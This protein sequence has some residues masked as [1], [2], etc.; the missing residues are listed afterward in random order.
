MSAKIH[1]LCTP[2]VSVFNGT[3]IARAIPA[4]LFPK[5]LPVARDV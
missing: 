2:E 5:P 4:S 3:L 1:K